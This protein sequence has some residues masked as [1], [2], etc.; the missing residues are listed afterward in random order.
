MQLMTNKRQKGQCFI[1]KAAGSDI[2]GIAQVFFLISSLCVLHVEK[3]IHETSM[4]VRLIFRDCNLSSFEAQQLVTRRAGIDETSFSLRYIIAEV[5]HIETYIHRRQE[6]SQA[7]EHLQ[8]ALS[9]REKQL[10]ELTNLLKAV[11]KEAEMRLETETKSRQKAN[12]EHILEVDSL[13]AQLQEAQSYEEELQLA[14]KE[15][16][17]YEQTIQSQQEELQSM[18][19]VQKELESVRQENAELSQEVQ[20]LQ[21]LQDDLITANDQIRELQTRLQSAEY[22]SQSQ[23]SQQQVSVII[24]GRHGS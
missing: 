23:T 22:S 7:N 14:L 11:Q 4:A 12:D 18:L 3:I 13:R 16:A 15:K 19:S 9:D 6:R 1:C 21:P 17:Q 20:N 2:V 24:L 10:S 8:A 5:P